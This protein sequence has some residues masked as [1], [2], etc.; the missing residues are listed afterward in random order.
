MSQYTVN[1]HLTPE[2]PDVCL[3]F[4]LL[5]TI[6]IIVVTQKL[7][8]QQSKNVYGNHIALS[9]YSILLGK[10]CSFS[11]NICTLQNTWNRKYLNLFTSPFPSLFYNSKFLT[12]SSHGLALSPYL[13]LFYFLS[14]SLLNF[15]N[16]PT[17]TIYIYSY[18]LFLLFIF[19]FPNNLLLIYLFSLVFP[20]AD[21]V[22]MLSCSL[23]FPTADHVLMLSCS[24]VF[25]TADPVLMFSCSLVFPI[26]DPVLMLSCFPYCISCSHDLVFSC[27]PY[28]RPC[29]P[30]LP[31]ANRSLSFS[32]YCRSCSHA[33]LFSC[34]PY[35][36][37]CC[38]PLLFSCFPYCRSCSHALL[39]SLLYILFL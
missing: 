20:T 28:C 1:L 31:S 8:L 3:S 29:S 10:Y 16:S 30:V 12:L 11:C 34:F 5:F 32:P 17:H 27:S 37:P 18:F 19:P 4:V 23:V 38:H 7:V 24:S 25:P 39:F 2:M 35:C 36:R 22:L 33:L 14:S 13:F 6:F 21:P 26:A 9:F 15:L